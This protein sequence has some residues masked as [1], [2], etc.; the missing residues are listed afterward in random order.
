MHGEANKKV[1]GI[2]LILFGS[3]VGYFSIKDFLNN[4]NIYMDSAIFKIGTI[5]FISLWSLAFV[6]FG[7]LLIKSHKKD[8]ENSEKR[9]YNGVTIDADFDSVSPIIRGGS[10]DEK[11]HHTWYSIT[12]SWVNPDDN[13]LYYFKSDSL[14]NNPEELIKEKNIT[15][16]KI[17]YEVGN[18]KNYEIDL[19]DVEECK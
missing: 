2:I 19:S 16:F 7:I 6:I 11:E 15:K 18:I 1:V 17:T 9:K 5:V 13:K 14:Y 12:C 3:F 8:K 10:I 4:N